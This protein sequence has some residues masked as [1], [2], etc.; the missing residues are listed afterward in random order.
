MRAVGF[1]F[2]RGRLDV[3][4]HPFCGGNG[5]FDVR[6][7]TR[8]DGADFTK[9]F[10]ATLHETGHGKYQQ[11]LPAKWLE[12]PV[13]RS[14]GMGIHESQSLL[15]EMQISRSRAFLA[16]SAPLMREVFAEQAQKQP[17][18]FTVTNLH[19]LLTRVR[20]SLI[21][22]EADEVTYPLHIILRYDIEKKL[23]NGTMEVHDIPEAW[24][25]GMCELFGLSTRDDFENGCMQDMHWP[26]GTFGYF[27]SYAL[28][29]MS[30]AQIFGAAEK[31]LPSLREDIAEG[32]FQTLDRFLHERIWQKG[33]LFTT[34]RLL[35]EATGG[36]LN[37]INYRQ[38]LQRRYL[39]SP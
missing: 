31:Q 23:F 18:A 19:R 37:P 27:P 5:V 17:E 25:E 30:A 22:V 33:C 6:I 32:H 14:R 16:F 13:G 2:D 39:D 34:D 24:D 26:S 9:A 21:R 8:Y 20:P 36:S 12:Q 38:H 15:H 28:G 7:T 4:P 1:D 10:Q 29:A 35:T 3:A 11:G